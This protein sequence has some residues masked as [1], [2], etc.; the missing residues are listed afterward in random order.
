MLIEL[1]KGRYAPTFK[2][3]D[4]PLPKRSMARALASRN[5]IAVLPFSDQSPAGDMQ[6]FCH[7]LAA[8]I[9]HTLTSSETVRVVSSG[10]THDHVEA[11]NDLRETATSLDVAMLVSGSVR[12]QASVVRILVQLIDGASGAYAWSESVEGD[13]GESFAMQEKVAKA[14]LTRLEDFVRPG[15][16][17]GST[18]TVENL[19]ARI[20]ICKAAST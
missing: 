12:K 18:G 3:L 13:L 9:V 16:N 17:K 5:T 15:S 11:L 14:V 19:A 2:R 7:G 20:Y 10:N 8:E 1:P 4:T 6:Y